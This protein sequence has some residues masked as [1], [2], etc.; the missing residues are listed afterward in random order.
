MDLD[1]RASGAMLQ[2]PIE[3]KRADDFLNLYSNNVFLESSLWDLKLVLGQTD[4]RLGLNVVVQ[5][6]AVTL[7]WAQVKVLLHLMGSHLIAHEIQNGRIQVPPNIIT[8][9]PDE[10]PKELVIQNPKLPEIHVALKARYD[11]FIAENPEA[12]PKPAETARAKR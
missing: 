10:P 4:Q 11:A 9:I 1:K 3:Y 12:L 7:P 5:N 2:S 8:P 6:A